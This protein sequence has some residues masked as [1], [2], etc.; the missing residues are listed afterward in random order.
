MA[1]FKL[2][3]IKFV[4]QGAWAQNNAYVVDDV[5]TVSGK[6][7]ICVVSHTSTNSATGFATDLAYNPTNW[8][9][10]ADGAKWIGAWSNG[11]Y[12][13]VS[14][15]VSYGGVIY[16]CL[17]SHTSTASAATITAT[18]FT[19]FAGTATLTYASQVVQPFLVGSTVT[20]SGFSPASTSTP[21]TVNSTFT[22]LTCTTTQITF[23]LTGTYTVSTLG[24]VAGT[25]QL[26]LEQDQ[27]K[28]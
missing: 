22:V 20:L 24:T 14:D 13:N 8:N 10:I 3:R 25:S 12:Y 21:S 1:E 9:L 28:W 16:Q 2:G 26:G 5:I 7:Y 4:Y 17:T 19:V 18:G 15:Q 11:T 6:T 27:A 23:T